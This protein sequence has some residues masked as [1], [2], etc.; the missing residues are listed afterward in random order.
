M[1]RLILVSSFPC[2][3]AR[4]VLAMAMVKHLPV[5]STALMLAVV[6]CWLGPPKLMMVWAGCSDAAW[7]RGVRVEAVAAGLAS[8]HTALGVG[9]R[10][11]YRQ[12]QQQ[13]HRHHCWL[14]LLRRATLS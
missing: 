3:Q 5:R 11:R 12:E 7:V 2:A 4:S 8:G 14:E 1:L 6:E 10:C 13:Q 9:R